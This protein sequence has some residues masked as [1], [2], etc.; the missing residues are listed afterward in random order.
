MDS[1]SMRRGVVAVKLG[2]SA[3]SLSL[4]AAVALFPGPQRAMATIW[5]GWVPG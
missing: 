5:E 1:P 3:R 2:M 4:G